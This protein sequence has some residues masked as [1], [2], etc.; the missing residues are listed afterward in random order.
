MNCRISRS[1]FDCLFAAALLLTAT[2]A[3]ADAAVMTRVLRQPLAADGNFQVCHGGGCALIDEGSLDADEW[4]RI[5]ATCSHPPPDAAAERDCI[6]R[7]IG[8]FEQIIGPKTGTATDR[9]GTF[10]NSAYPGQMDCN[11]EAI[12]TTTYLRLMAMRGLLQYHDVQDI[13]RRGFFLNGWPHSSAVI[14]DRQSQARYAVDS[15]FYDN[16]EPAVVLPFE[17]WKA[18]WKPSDSRA[19]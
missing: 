16:G 7:T 15:W 4:R 13:R 19:R 2:Q 9:G 6:A 11:D 14:R 8:R 1:F 18:G 5:E 12:N 10:G 3:A 17:Q